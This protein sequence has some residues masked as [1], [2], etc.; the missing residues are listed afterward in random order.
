VSRRR[1]PFLEKNPKIGRVNRRRDGDRPT[2]EPVFKL[3]DQEGVLW[4]KARQKGE[5]SDQPPPGQ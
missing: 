4:K 1:H 3:E 5:E 2:G